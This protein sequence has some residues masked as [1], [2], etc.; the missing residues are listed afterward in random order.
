MAA[1]LGMQVDIANY[2]RLMEEARDKAEALAA[3][4][5]MTGSTA[6]SSLEAWIT[7]HVSSATRP[8]LVE[9]AIVEDVISSDGNQSSDGLRAGQSG[10]V[11]LDKTPFYAEAGGQVG[12]HG[13]LRGKDFEFRVDDTR[14]IRD[15]WVHIGTCVSGRFDQAYRELRSAAAL[16]ETTCRSRCQERMFTAKRSSNRLVVTPPCETTPPRTS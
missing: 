6:I 2:E 13:I 15:A 9:D 16:R 7:Q 10:L 3:Q 1:E 12:D 5:H 8:R 11:V 14:R 4:P